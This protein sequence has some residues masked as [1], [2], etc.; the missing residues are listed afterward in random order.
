MGSRYGVMAKIIKCLIF[1]S[2]NAVMVEALL[3]NVP[4]LRYGEMAKIVTFS[5]FD[6][7]IKRR[8]QRR[9]G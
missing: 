5:K 7:E 1:D 2:D 8:G 3:P 6:I 9:F 4:Y